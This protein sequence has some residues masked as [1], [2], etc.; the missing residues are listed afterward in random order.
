MTPHYREL[1]DI[2]AISWP[3]QEERFSGHGP[4]MSRIT[5]EV[6]AVKDSLTVQTPSR[7]PIGAGRRRTKGL[8]GPEGICEVTGEKHVLKAA[9]AQGGFPRKKCRGC[10]ATWRVAE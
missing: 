1:M 4:C 10:G 6:A 5:G 7:A 8:S 2:P 9:S 3:D